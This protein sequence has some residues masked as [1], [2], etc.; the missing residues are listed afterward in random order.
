MSAVM[1]VCSFCGKTN[2]DVMLIVRGLED[3]CI[4]DE[5]ISLCNEIL[6]NKAKEAMRAL[7]RIE[8]D[9]SSAIQYK[10]VKIPTGLRMQVFERDSHTC[11]KCGSTENLTVDHIHPEILG[12]GID[13]DNLQTLCRSCNSSKGSRFI[14]GVSK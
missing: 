6:V 12:G 7:P 1:L 13:L 4:C 2:D 8:S 9:L 11:K 3:S 5:C 14:G 10:K